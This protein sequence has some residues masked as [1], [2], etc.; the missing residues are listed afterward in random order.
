LLSDLGHFRE[1][2]VVFDH[3][4]TLPENKKVTTGIL[5][6]CIFEKLLSPTATSRR[7]RRVDCKTS[8]DLTVT[9]KHPTP[10]AKLPTSNGLKFDAFAVN[11]S[12]SLREICYSKVR[13][14]TLK[15]RAQAGTLCVPDPS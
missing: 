6:R 4:N 5:E 15:F 1:N 8:V 11:I 12:G 2:A 9:G 10:N 3:Q 7:L 13:H 14:A